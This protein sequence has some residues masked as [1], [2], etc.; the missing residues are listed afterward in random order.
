MEENKRIEINFRLIDTKQVQFALLAN[1]WPQGEMQIGNQLNFG[2]DTEKRI[3]RCTATFEYKLHDVTQLILTVQTTFEF[4]REGWSAMYQLHGDQWVLPAGLV[5]HMADVTTGAARG[6]LAIRSEEAGI[7]RLVL[8]LL[9]TQDV[10]QHN[11][12]LPRKPRGPQ[13]PT[14]PDG[15]SSA[16]A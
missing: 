8:P 5:Q 3:V 7:P 11:M 1:E 16:N 9:R 14:M 4:A 13:M 10:I 2:S 12:A 6:I 15:K